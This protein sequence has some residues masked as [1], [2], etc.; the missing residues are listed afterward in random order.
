MASSTTLKSRLQHSVGFLFAFSP[1]FSTHSVVPHQGSSYLNKAHN[2]RL[3]LP[4]SKS[5]S[6]YIL[7]PALAI[8]L[9]HLF[10]FYGLR[11]PALDKR[12]HG[13]RKHHTNNNASPNQF[14]CPF[15]PMTTGL[16]FP[17]N[18]NQPRPGYSAPH[19]WVSHLVFRRRWQC[20]IAP[21]SNPTARASF[22]PTGLGSKLC[23]NSEAFSESNTFVEPSTETTK[24]FGA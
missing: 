3:T 14:Y 20:S 9:F 23:L 7:Y 6:S 15:Q 24:P 5:L 18:E 13:G 21:E 16:P 2:E 22:P 11:L 1:L 8:P 12:R 17:Q 10:S 19:P 4:F